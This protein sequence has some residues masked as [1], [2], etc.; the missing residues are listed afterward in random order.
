MTRDVKTMVVSPTGESTSKLLKLSKLFLRTDQPPSPTNVVDVPLVSPLCEDI[1]R[2]VCSMPEEDK[3]V[4]LLRGIVGDLLNE[5][6]ALRHRLEITENEVT[7][8]K[9]EREQVNVLDRD[10]LLSL[11]MALKETTGEPIKIKMTPDT[12]ISSEKATELVI[13]SLTR[14]IENLNIDNSDLAEQNSKLRER[15]EEMSVDAESQSQKIDALEKQFNR[16]NKT[17][18]K[19]VSR[20]MDRSSY[21][22]II[23][24]GIGTNTNRYSKLD[25]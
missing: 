21:E 19:V 11:L 1:D 17:R 8:L 25:V 16:I 20:I 5:C 6:E 24:P 10:R 15:I 2:V 12:V 18:Q 22:P 7:S 9:H 4:Q 3:A 23:T 14:K 13:H